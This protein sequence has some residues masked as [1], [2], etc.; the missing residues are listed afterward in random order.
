MFINY[1]KRRSQVKHEV[2]AIIVLVVLLIVSV[3]EAKNSSVVESKEKNKIIT[4]TAEN[5][6]ITQSTTV[7][8]TTTSTTTTATTTIKST[9][10]KKTKPRKTDKKI[11]YDKNNLSVP[12]VR[13]FKSYTNYHLL[14][15]SSPQWRF[16]TQ[17]G[18]YTDS[19]G[20]RRIN[21]DYMVAVGSY[22]SKTL[23]D[24]FEI[25]T[26]KGNV[27]TV[28]ICDFKSDSHTDSTHRYTRVN[29]CIAEFYV[30]RNLNSSIRS[31]G[32]VSAIKSLS[33]KIIKIRKIK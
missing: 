2:L 5:T 20:L 25:T 23:G 7:V 9:S 13:D 30:D 11:T 17:K 10:A 32:S 26:D 29:G 21:N 31:A 22:Y 28:S 14:S 33:G 6:I 4:T 18:A 12:N 19:N 1:K 8:N 3:C 15:K 24:R 16:V 27:F